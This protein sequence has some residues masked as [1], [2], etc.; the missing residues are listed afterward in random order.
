MFDVVMRFNIKIP[1][2][3]SSHIQQHTLDSHHRSGGEAMPRQL[4]SEGADVAHARTQVFPGT[5]DE[6]CRKNN[7]EMNDMWN[8]KSQNPIKYIISFNQHTL[9]A[10]TRSGGGDARQLGSEGGGDQRWLLEAIGE[11]GGGRIFLL[12][13]R[14]RGCV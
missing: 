3:I 5:C 8:V 13:A 1:S 10:T 4:C 9:E 6:F 2:N 11:G 14:W 7:W 12:V